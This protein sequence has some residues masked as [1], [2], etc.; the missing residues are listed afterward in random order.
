[1]ELRDVAE[2]GHRWLGTAPSPGEQLIPQNLLLLLF[3]GNVEVE[4]GKH[5][6]YGCS[7]GTALS[8]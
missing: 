5:R 1:M 4:Q 6:S 2:V 8:A 7:P 3:F